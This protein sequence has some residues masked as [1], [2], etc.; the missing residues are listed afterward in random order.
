MRFAIA[1][2]SL[3]LLL[4]AAGPG[5]AGAA[6]AVSGGQVTGLVAVGALDGDTLALSDGSR[7][8]LAAIE[9]PRLDPG[10]PDAK[11][12]PLSREAQAAL[13]RLAVGHHLSLRPVRPSRDRFG[14]RLAY[15]FDDAGHLVQGEMVERGLARV[16]VL[17]QGASPL[18]KG[19]GA[20]KLFASL[21]ADEAAARQARLGIWAL[22]FYRVRTPEAAARTGDGYVLVDG[23]VQ[24]VVLARR[25]V[26]LLLAGA[27]GPGWRLS[28]EVP[29]K[30]HGAFAR[31]RIDLDRLAGRRVLIRGWIAGQGKAERVMRLARPQ[32]MELLPTG[33]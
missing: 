2:L 12:W 4:L 29:A 15:A 17:A 25:A 5:P 20:K 23:Q 8:R 22:P 11:P 28:V 27:S 6:G 30:A 3:V 7:L 18:P 26:Y 32:Q 31:A 33:N 9:A 10:W 19:R 21:L 16:Y 1:G 13:A 24:S 14:R